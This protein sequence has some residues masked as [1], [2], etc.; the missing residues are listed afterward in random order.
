MVCIVVEDLDFDMLC[1]FDIVFEEDV[2][3]VEIV[4][5]QLYDVVKGFGKLCSVGVDVYVDVVVVCGGFE[6]YWIVD[7]IGCGDCGCRIGQQVCIWC[8]CDI[9]G[10]GQCVSCVFE[11]EFDDILCCW[12]DED[13]FCIGVG[14]CEFG[15]F[16]EKFI[17]GVDSFSVCGVCCV[18]YCCDVQIIF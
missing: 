4:C 2:V 11:V 9:V 10:F 18:E 3:V 17:I 13:D 5:V 16:R 14:L 15:I 1:C 6:D 8:Q 12:V 7:C